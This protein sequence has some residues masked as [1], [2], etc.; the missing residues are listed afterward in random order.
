MFPLR[1]P[2]GKKKNTAEAGLPNEGD[3]TDFADSTPVYVS[4]WFCEL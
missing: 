1:V 4:L 2:E 3:G